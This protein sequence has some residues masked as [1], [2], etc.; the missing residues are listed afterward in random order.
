MLCLKKYEK[1]TFLKDLYFEFE[2]MQYNAVFVHKKLVIHV[3]F[4]HFLK[5]QR[6]PKKCGMSVGFPLLLT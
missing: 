6:E 4:M 3:N 2:P 5:I 1:K